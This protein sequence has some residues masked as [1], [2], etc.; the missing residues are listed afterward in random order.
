MRVLSLFSGIGALDY[1]LQNAGF[2]IAG[3]CEI[4][5]FPRRVLAKHWPN[6]P[7]FKDVQWV[8]RDTDLGD[9]PR[10]G[11]AQRPLRPAGRVARGIT[12]GI[13]YFFAPTAFLVV[14]AF[15]RWRR[16]RWRAFWRAE[17]SRV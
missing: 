13:G 14:I 9:L 7:K 5:E 12:K 1:G 2:E 8:T 10:K 15:Y 11:A 3:Q 6:V 17:M 16:D 4:E